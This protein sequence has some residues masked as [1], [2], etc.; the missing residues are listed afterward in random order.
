LGEESALMAIDFPASPNVGQTVTVG[1][2]TWTWDGTKWVAQGTGV[3]VYL[4]LTGGT[5]TGDLIL[6]RD[7]QVALGAAT[8]QQADAAA[9]G[10]RIINGDMRIDQRGV[11]S[12]AGGTAN[13]GYTVDRWQYSSTTTRGTWSRGGPFANT[14]AFGFPYTLQFTSSSAYTPLAGDV[15]Y[16]FQPIEAD[17]V[18]D[19]A[20]GT[21]NAQPATLSF[22]AYSSLGGTLSGAIRNM[23][24]AGPVT[25]SYPFSFSLAASTWTKVVIPIPGDTGGTWVMAGT[26]GGVAVAFDLGSGATFR[27]PA[28]AWAAANYVGATG[29]VNTVG[30][31]GAI[32]SLTGVKLEVGS[33]AA[34][35]NRQSPAKSLADC[36]RYYYSSNSI[37]FAGYASAGTGVGQTLLF[38]VPMRAAPTLV[39][40]A[41]TTATNCVA[42]L[43]PQIATVTNIAFNTGVSATG[44]FIY[45]S[46]GFTAS[47]E[48]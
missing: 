32:F 24:S 19:F 45:S 29:A 27:G 12:G 21:A 39:Y 35:Y 7:A 2:V 4:P 46:P 43:S 18:S 23:P 30:T 10:N 6:N 40:A 17:F 36:Q 15:C 20:W 41:A 5:M 22:W 11:A 16:F 9:G 14:T 28:N 3:G 1:G 26:A 8:K 42:A 48:L 44:G 31:N 38:P 47:A 34:A 33:I 13:G 25:R 37:W